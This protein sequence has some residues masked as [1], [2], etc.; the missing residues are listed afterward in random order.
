MEIVNLRT[1]NT[2]IVRNPDNFIDEYKKHILRV[3]PMSY[4]LPKG[5]TYNVNYILQYKYV[6]DRYTNSTKMRIVLVKTNKI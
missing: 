5:N 2:N 3:N 6:E 4:F 1:L